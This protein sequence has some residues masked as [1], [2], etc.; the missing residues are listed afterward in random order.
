MKKISVSQVLEAGEKAVKS[1]LPAAALNLRRWGRAA[2]GAL[3]HRLFETLK[4]RE[5]WDLKELA[6]KNFPAR[7]A[8]VLKAL[9]WTLSLRAPPMERLIRDGEVEWGYQYKTPFGLLEGQ[10][11]LWGFFP[12]SNELWIVDYKTGRP[13]YEEK[14]LR[15]LWLYSLALRRLHPAAKI[16]LAVIYPFD[17]RLSVREAG[18]AEP[19]WSPLGEI[20]NWPSL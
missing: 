8:E 7:S 6:D 20:Q 4:Y 11:D 14:A 3:M 2:E 12:A 5:D 10:I 16:K 15:Q 18:A 19:S 17:E 1:G 13:E 9:E